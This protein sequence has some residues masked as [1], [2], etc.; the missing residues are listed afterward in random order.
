MSTLTGLVGGGGGI[1]IVSSYP[2][3]S[4]QWRSSYTAQ[5]TTTAS[6]QDLLNISGASGYLLSASVTAVVPTSAFVRVIIIV[7]GTTIYDKDNFFSGDNVVYQFWPPSNGFF[8][9]STIAVVEGNAYASAFPLR[10]ESSLR[11]RVSGA[12]GT[13]EGVHVLT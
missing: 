9:R 7:D 12:I 3:T 2:I 8:N 13:V 5:L 11:V 6:L 10:F 4:S 1:P